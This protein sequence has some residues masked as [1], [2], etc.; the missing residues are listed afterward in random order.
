MNGTLG[1]WSILMTFLS[2]IAFTGILDI[3]HVTQYLWR[4]A[5]ALYGEKSS[6][7]RKW[8]YDNL[9]VILEGHVCDV[10]DKLRRML[11]TQTSKNWNEYD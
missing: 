1:L 11:E 7:G 6:S 5:N 2:A 4:V 8:D 10:I 3:I 9:L